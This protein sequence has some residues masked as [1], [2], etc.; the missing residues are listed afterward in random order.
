MLDQ[1]DFKDMEGQSL[2][3]EC[4][5]RVL[6]EDDDLLGMIIEAFMVK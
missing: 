4:K 3:R 2:R 5:G 1:L 6:G